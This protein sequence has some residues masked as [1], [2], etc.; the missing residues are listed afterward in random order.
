MKTTLKAL[1]AHLRRNSDVIVTKRDVLV[2]GWDPT[3]GPQDPHTETIEVVDFD[4]LLAEIDAFAETFGE[5][6]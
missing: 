2:D 4:T 3:Y 6:A 1:V 5:L